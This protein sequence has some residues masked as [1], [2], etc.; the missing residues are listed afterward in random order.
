MAGLRE[1]L[2]ALELEGSMESPVPQKPTCSPLPL[3]GLDGPAA[4]EESAAS[5]RRCPRLEN[6]LPELRAFFWPAWA[7]LW[8]G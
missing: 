4:R 8:Q 7:L 6:R 3:E 1:A 5:W 2:E